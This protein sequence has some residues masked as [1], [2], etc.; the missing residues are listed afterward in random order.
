MLHTAGPASL[1]APSYARLKKID[2]PIHH[3]C[4][5]QG[6]RRVDDLTETKALVLDRDAVFRHGRN[7]TPSDERAEVLRYHSLFFRNWQ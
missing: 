6:G 7:R 3:R 1:Y 4:T 5:E 2:A